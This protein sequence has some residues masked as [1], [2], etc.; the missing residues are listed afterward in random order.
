MRSIYPGLIDPVFSIGSATAGETGQ[1]G[2]KGT[3]FAIPATPQGGGQENEVTV[4][5]TEQ[6]TPDTVT[7]ILEGGNAVDAN[8]DLVAPLEVLATINTPGN[9]L[10]IRQK[11]G[12]YR[13]VRLNLPV[14]T[15]VLAEVTGKIGM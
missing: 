3:T 5:Y 9:D 8:E 11:I 2:V 13:F 15:G 4:E 14:L 6:V 12:R 1:T 10:S 7:L